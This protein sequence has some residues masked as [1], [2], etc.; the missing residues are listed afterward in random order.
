FTFFFTIGVVTIA[1][2]LIW[3]IKSLQHMFQSLL[4]KKIEIIG[5]DKK[6][7]LPTRIETKR[8]YHTPAG[9]AYRFN[10]QLIYEQL[11][12]SSTDQEA[13]L[14][15]QLSSF[16]PN[17]KYTIVFVAPSYY[18]LIADQN[19]RIFLTHLKNVNEIKK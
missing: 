6:M 15:P 18:A 7:M 1:G 9:P 8:R 13:Y 17:A 3:Y 2:Y 14:Y 4:G 16:A 10:K 5:I 11:F 12:E 19:N